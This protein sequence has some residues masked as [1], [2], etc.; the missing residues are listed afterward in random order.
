M[1]LNAGVEVLKIS[2]FNGRM[3]RRDQS[4]SIANIFHFIA[5]TL[6]NIAQPK[7]VDQIL[8]QLLNSN[9][10]TIRIASFKIPCLAGQY[11]YLEEALKQHMKLLV[12]HK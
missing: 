11:F 9:Y 4:C 10:Y 1:I 2:K 7:I 12:L 3:L 5:T 6:E 8:Q